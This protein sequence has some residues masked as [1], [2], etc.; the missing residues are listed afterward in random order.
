MATD[1][2]KSSEDLKHIALYDLHTVSSHISAFLFSSSHPP[3]SP[4]PSFSL[5]PVS[6]TKLFKLL[7]LC[8]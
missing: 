2:Q 3:S 1:R 7:D 6:L 8:F 4:P 5:A